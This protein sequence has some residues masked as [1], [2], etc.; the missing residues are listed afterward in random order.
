MKS[1]KIKR[2]EFVF[3]YHKNGKT[4]DIQELLKGKIQ[5]I[6]S[7]KMLAF[8]VLNG[9]E[10]VISDEEF[11]ILK[12]ISI[13]EWVEFNENPG[14]TL[15][16][17]EKFASV[18]IL[19]FD[20]GQEEFAQYIRKEDTLNKSKWNIYAAFFH[21]LTKWSK[22]DVEMVTEDYEGD[23]NMDLYEQGMDNVIK[24]NGIPPTHF[25]KINSEN[26][27]MLP[28]EDLSDDTYYQTILKRKT[29]RIFNKNISVKL[30]TLSTML[31][32][33][34]GCHGKYDMHKQLT[35]LHKTVPS[36]GSL[37]PTEAYILCLNIES[38]EPGIYHYN[39]EMHSLDLIK[40]YN[41][42]EAKDFANKFVAGQHYV[43]DAGFLLLMTTRYFRNFWKYQQHTLAYKVTLL[44]TGHLS[45]MFYLNTA[46]ET[47]GSFVTG[48]INT[49]LIE[50]ELSLDGFTE[51][52]TLVVGCGI[53]LNN[54]S[55]NLLEPNFLKH[56]IVR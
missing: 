47:L 14:F 10:I 39:V 19:L 11:E 1:K 8:P 26:R 9:E 42:K 13:T 7:R 54:E 18:G 15:Q 33:T 43:K 52:A 44:D 25:H 17:L 34:F 38:L 53:P 31:L 20:N 55:V 3:F 41:V 48:A 27:I 21:Y 40:I 49:S 56:E 22:V 24:K 37:H 23:D 29:S 35:L 5:Q 4:L 16:F 45:Q 36:G 12:S 50:Q 28:L 6:E 30:G 32:Y 2:S 51:G 46:K